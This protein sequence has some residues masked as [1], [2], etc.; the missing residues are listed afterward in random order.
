MI[1]YADTYQLCIAHLGKKR[2]QSFQRRSNLINN[3]TSPEQCTILGGLREVLFKS[4]E[5]CFGFRDITVTKT[6]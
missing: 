2:K 3:S 6:V 5:R 4:P 1:V